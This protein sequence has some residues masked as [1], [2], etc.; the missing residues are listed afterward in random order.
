M[1]G[2][3][4]LFYPEDEQSLLP[5]ELHPP[6]RDLGSMTNLETG[7]HRRS[8]EGF[9]QEEPTG[10]RG[11]GDG[12]EEDSDCDITCQHQEQEKLLLYDR[13][14][15]F[16]VVTQYYTPEDP[17]RAREVRAIKLH[18]CRWAG[19]S[20]LSCH[21]S[22]NPIRGCVDGGGSRQRFGLFV[23]CTKKTPTRRFGLFG[24]GNALRCLTPFHPIVP[25]ISLF[26]RA[27]ST[28]ACCTTFRTR[29]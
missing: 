25:L 15:V 17:S 21:R 11:G 1:A 29:S 8:M 14:S 12:E 10:G 5:Q 19:L 2:I 13:H 7:R 18:E 27:R 3:E 16:H 22:V 4:P 6:R 9:G 26:M 23:V 20:L 28:L 24:R